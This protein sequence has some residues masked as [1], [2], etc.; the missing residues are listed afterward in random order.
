MSSAVAPGDDTIV[1]T[2]NPM[3]PACVPRARAR[4]L[5]GGAPTV[6]W[7]GR[8][9]QRAA[10]A[11]TARDLVGLDGEGG[12]VR[13]A[14]P[15]GPRACGVGC[16]WCCWWAGGRPGGHTRRILL[17]LLLLR[18]RPLLLVLQRSGCPAPRAQTFYSDCLHYSVKDE[19]EEAEQMEDEEE[20]DAK[21]CCAI[22]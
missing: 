9:M 5:K 14:R 6:L 3:Q 19:E 7:F 8:G 22:S 17:A 18:A 21:V 12:P 11:K 20:E 15:P 10:A 13:G 4:A 1:E 2:Q 16:L